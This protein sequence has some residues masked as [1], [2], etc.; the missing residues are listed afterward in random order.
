[1]ATMRAV[2]IKDGKGPIENLYIGETEKPVAGPGE[3]LIKAF[4]LN[5]LDIIQREGNYP[6]PPGSS[7]VL[8]V[9]F[10]G[11]VSQLGE[12][13]TIWK[14]GDDVFGLAGGGAYAEYIRVPDTHLIRKPDRMSWAEAASI[15]EAFLTAFQSLIVINELKAGD[16]VL[17]HAGAS[18][19]GIA[20]TQ[21]ARVYNASTISVTASSDAKL[22]QL[23]TSPTP[24]THGINYKMQDFSQQ[25]KSITGGKGVD[26]LLDFVGQSHWTKNID[27]LALDGRI[28]LQG[29]LSGGNVAEFNL[30]P[31]LSKRLKIQG[32]TLRSR[33][34]SYQT[35]LIQRFA[36]E[37]LPKMGADG[38]IRL[39]IH[40]VFPW[41]EIQR[42][43]KEMEANSNAGKIVVEVV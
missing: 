21:L 25:V 10:S 39:Y 35:D 36:K 33:S 5:R 11:Q 24:P 31:I 3:V 22:Q 16:D 1:M 28:S 26:V 7:D 32:S 15:P 43:H 9:E 30:A 17:I 38:P 41:T 14:V 37:V 13:V 29:L 27:S 40:K 18:G 23:L 42:A 8:G 34:L 20:A 12:G 6:P 4:A 2:L 19:V